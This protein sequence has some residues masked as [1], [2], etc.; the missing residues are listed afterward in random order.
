VENF[1]DQFGYFAL[2]A[3]TFLEGETAILVASSLI[4]RGVFDAPYT[5]LAGF[6]GSFISDWLYYIVGRLNGRYFIAKRPALHARLVPVQTFFETHKLQ[7]LLTYRFLYGFRVIIPLII[8][9]STV[10]PVQFLVYSVVSGML[11]ATIVSTVGYAIGRFLDLKTSVFEEN[12]LFIILG[13][14]CFGMLLGYVIK[15][16][17]LRQMEESESKA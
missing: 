14:A 9:M 12:L 17:T 2:I 6:A 4:Y 8:G 3:G 7:I 16:V 10:R 5:I 15:R 1:L 11:W 13:F